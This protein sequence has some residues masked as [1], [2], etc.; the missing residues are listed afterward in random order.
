MAWLLAHQPTSVAQTAI[1]ANAGPD[2]ASVLVGESV[3]LDGSASSGAITQ[4]AWT[5]VSRA[6]GSRAVITNP[7]AV[8]ANF[9]P[10]RRGTYVV[11]LT[12]GNGTVTSRLARHREHHD[13]EQA[14][15]GE[16]R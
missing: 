5:F 8:V 7:N 12:V 15:R 16:R 1:V 11:R 2:Q 4:Y 6:S 10:D 14:A 9:V 13:R 3:A